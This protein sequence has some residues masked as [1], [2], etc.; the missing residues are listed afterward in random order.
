[1]IMWSSQQMPNKT[2]DKAQHQF[3]HNET[4]E[5]KT[6]LSSC[7]RGLLQSDEGPHEKPRD[8]IILDGET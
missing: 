4:D 1:M 8:D 3:T 5:S 7:R 2:T 6:P